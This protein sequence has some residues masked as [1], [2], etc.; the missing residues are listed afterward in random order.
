MDRE[1]IRQM[2][3]NATGW[4]LL[5]DGHLIQ[6]SFF[7]YNTALVGWTVTILFFVYQFMLYM[8]ARNLTLNF[9]TGLMFVGLFVVNNT[10]IK[11]SSKK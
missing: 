4:N 2:I 5:I 1:R 3:M 7:M 10:L 6:A 8:K 9:I 11:I